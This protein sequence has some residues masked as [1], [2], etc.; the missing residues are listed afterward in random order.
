MEML[1][2]WVRH[3]MMAASRFCTHPATLRTAS[4]CGMLRCVQRTP[5]IKHDGSININCDAWFNAVVLSFQT[6]VA[7]VHIKTD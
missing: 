4:P 2:L 6:F 1:F 7:K 3:Q 5:A